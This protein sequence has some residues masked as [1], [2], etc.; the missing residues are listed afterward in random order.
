MKS[1]KRTPTPSDLLLSMTIGLVQGYYRNMCALLLSEGEPAADLVEYARDVCLFSE[2]EIKRMSNCTPENKKTMWVS[3]ETSVAILS[4]LFCSPELG[5]YV[6]EFVVSQDHTK[7]PGFKDSFL[8]MIK[9][10]AETRAKAEA[11][12]ESWN[13]E[14]SQS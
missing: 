5:E 11:I 10:L 6:T 4:N 12:K 13:K 3:A 2:G 1:G 9:E 14:A 7:R 8:R